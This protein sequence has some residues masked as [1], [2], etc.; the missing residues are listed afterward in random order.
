MSRTIHAVKNPK[1]LVSQMNVSYR[2]PLKN[3]EK[4]KHLFKIA[5]QQDCDFLVLPEYCNGI[6]SKCS[7]SQDGL[8]HFLNTIKKL[9]KENN[10]YTIAG[11]V[12]EKEKNSYYNTS[13]F[14]SRNGEVLGKHRKIALVKYYES[15]V[16]S[17]GERL[18]VFPTEFGPV[19]I[20]ICRDMLYPHLSQQLSQ[21]DAKIIF[22]PA[23]WSYSSLAYFEEENN[24]E[25]DYPPQAE[26]TTLKHLPI[27]RAIENETFFIVANAGGSTVGKGCNEKLAG[28]SVIA[29]PLHGCLASLSHMGESHLIH[30]LNMS[31]LEDSKKTYSVIDTVPNHNIY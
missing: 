19:G 14:I 31:I 21:K 17:P 4:I 26:F 16:L 27:T 13:Y 18:S 30:E 20:L 24:L 29:A 10:I 28:H 3:L 6:F 1:V 7:F 23:F 2:D 5:S 12:L 15:K 8:Q 9:S 22:C 11:S 25:N